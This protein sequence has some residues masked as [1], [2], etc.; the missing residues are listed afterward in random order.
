MENLYKNYISNFRDFSKEVWVL[1]M[2]TYIN[3]AGAMVMFFLPKYLHTH[4]YFSYSEISWMLA[5]IGIGS[6]SGAW[7]G[8]KF[9]DKSGF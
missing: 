1:A 4:L 5:F 3:R 9:T 7:L 8:G 6:L 2:I